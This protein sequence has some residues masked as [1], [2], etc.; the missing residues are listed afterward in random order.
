MQWRIEAHMAT[1]GQLP[2]SLTEVYEGLDMPESPED[3]DA[4]QYE[5]TGETTY[6]LCATFTSDRQDRKDEYSYAVPVAEKGYNPQNYNWEHG[7]GET[8]FERT[9]TKPETL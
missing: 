7:V 5:V 3:R 8:C 6:N 1:N 4:Y 9:V 2:E